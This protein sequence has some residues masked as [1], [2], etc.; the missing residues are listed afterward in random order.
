[1]GN[2]AAPHELWSN[3]IS[4]V[5]TLDDFMRVTM[6]RSV[7]YIADQQCPY[8]EEFDGN[9]FCGMHLI[10]WSGEEPAACLRLRF[11]GDFAKLERLAVRPEFRRST[12]SFRIVRLGLQIAARKGYRTAYGHA[13]E[14][15]EPFWARFG[16]RPM[17]ELRSF[18]FSGYRYTEMVV[19]LPE[20]NDAI[21]IGADPMVTIRPEGAWDRPG[22]LERRERPL[23]AGGA[24]HGQGSSGPRPSLE[25]LLSRMAIELVT[26]QIRQR[27]TDGLRD[28]A[29][30]ARDVAA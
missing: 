22:V 9:D 5:R 8:D 30:G 12:L 27:V 24:D 15:L 23:P 11:F 26:L 19:D 4:I 28:I 2:G 7:V 17:G 16:A 18:T 20:S 14:G 25:S 29:V 10:G 6:I 13:Q 1:M 3:R 21:T